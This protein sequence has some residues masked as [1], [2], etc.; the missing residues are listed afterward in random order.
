MSS[1]PIGSSATSDRRGAPVSQN[2]RMIAVSRSPAKS[3]P[4]QAF[5]IARITSGSGIGTGLPDGA[6]G[7]T[8]AIGETSSSCSAA[9]QL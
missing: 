7:I 8:R 1:C 6:G 9:A 3:L 5:R 2:S 4:S